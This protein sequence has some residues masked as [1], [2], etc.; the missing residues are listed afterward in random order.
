MDGGGRRGVAGETEEEYRDMDRGRR[1]ARKK[2]YEEDC[3]GGVVEG[4]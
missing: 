2:E 1:N 4:V 3:T